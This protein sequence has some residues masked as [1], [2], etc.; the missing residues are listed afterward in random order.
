MTHCSIQL[1]MYRKNRR[2]SNSAFT[3]DERGNAIRLA[4]ER[5]EFCCV[6]WGHVRTE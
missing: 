3:L 4:Q 2:G 6:T 1:Q 5:E